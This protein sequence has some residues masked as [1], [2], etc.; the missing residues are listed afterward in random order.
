MCSL[1]QESSIWPK[2]MC[3]LVN[4]NVVPEPAAPGNLS[5][6]QNIRPYSRP[7]KSDIYFTRCVGDSY[8]H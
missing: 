4:S 7:T 5:E 2:I 6:M 1:F 8:A 3:T